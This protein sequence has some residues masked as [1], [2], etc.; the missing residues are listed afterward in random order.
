MTE[1]I[2]AQFYQGM[3]LGLFLG[4]VLGYFISKR[5][6]KKRTTLTSLQILSVFMFF[7]YIILSDAMGRP[8][9]EFISALILSLTG[10]EAIGSA[11]QK[12][13]RK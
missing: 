1:A 8:P 3:A 5:Y 6:D 13:L 9:S 11:I 12:G 7:G 2:T 4:A 10:G